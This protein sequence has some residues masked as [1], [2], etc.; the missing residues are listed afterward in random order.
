MAFASD[1][2]GFEYQFVSTPLDIFVCKI[3]RL[4]SRDPHLTMCCGH[5]FCKSCL[6]VMK[7]VKSM[8]YNKCPVCRG[9][10]FV[11]FP[12]KQIDR[13]V[14]SLHVYCTI[15]SRGCEWQGEVNYID[16]HLTKDGGCGYQDVL[17]SSGCGGLIQRRDLT[18][19]VENECPRR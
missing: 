16:N 7:E 8:V 13:E 2:G 15:K 4:P 11:T 10:D 9:E 6:D 1:C 17:C 14:K 5:V 3:C 18:K 12:N 19:H